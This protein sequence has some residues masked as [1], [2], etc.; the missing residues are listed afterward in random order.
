MRAA[1]STKIGCTAV[2]RRARRNTIADRPTLLRRPL[3]RPEL[4]DLSL[5]D[6]VALLESAQT[7]LELPEIDGASGR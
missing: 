4:Q 7:L 1:S 6:L 2:K 5:D 3:A